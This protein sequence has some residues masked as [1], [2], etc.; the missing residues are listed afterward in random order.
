M[1]FIK[2]EQL[3]A[4]LDKHFADANDIRKRKRE[5]PAKQDNRPL[6]NSYQGW[7]QQGPGVPL[8]QGNEI[9]G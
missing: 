1:R 2:N 7:I 3:K 6:F 5:N 8:G 4:H 9:H